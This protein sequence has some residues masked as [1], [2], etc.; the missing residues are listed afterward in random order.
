MRESRGSALVTYDSKATLFYF[1]LAIRDL[2][3]SET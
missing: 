2:K 3:I 1:L